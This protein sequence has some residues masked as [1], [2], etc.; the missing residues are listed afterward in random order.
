VKPLADGLYQAACGGSAF[1]S[2]SP[3]RIECLPGGS[4]RRLLV[5]SGHD[6]A[7]LK[8]PLILG[9]LLLLGMV[10][11]VADYILET[12]ERERA[13]FNRA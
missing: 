1:T 13:L 4:Q 12:V 3:S 8:G 5:H 10:R 2:G 11:A 7:Y 6:D 9:K